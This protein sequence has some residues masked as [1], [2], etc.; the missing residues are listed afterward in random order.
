MR[1]KSEDSPHVKD[2]RYNQLQE[3]DKQLSKTLGGVTG[4]S[5]FISD[6]LQKIDPLAKLNVFTRIEG[7]RVLAL[8]KTNRLKEYDEPMRRQFLDAVLET[9]GKQEATKGKNVYVGI[10]GKLLY[11]LTR[12]PPDEVKIGESVPESALMGFYGEPASTPSPTPK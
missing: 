9:L 10:K 5:A 2:P 4:L 8:V 12:I 3:D 1:I 7:D 11:G 6:R